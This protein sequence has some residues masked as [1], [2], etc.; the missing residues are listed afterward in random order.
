MFGRWGYN[1]YQQ[2]GKWKKAS[3][4]VAR[5]LAVAMYYMMMTDKPF[6]YENFNLMKSIDV[7]DIPVSELPLLNPDF[8]RYVRILEGNGI[9]TTS[10]MANAYLSC[11]LG[12]VN[13]LGRKFFSTIRDF[14]NSQHKYKTLYNELKKGG[15][16]NEP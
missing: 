5:K 10:Q 13:G 4:A 8:K 11:E 1:L 3:N 7:F 6:S 9:Y 12:P 14:L 16:Q 15:T 2:T